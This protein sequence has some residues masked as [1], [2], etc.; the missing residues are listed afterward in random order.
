MARPA[1]AIVTGFAKSRALAE[2]SL[3]PLRQLRQASVLRDI[4]CLTWDSPEIDPYAGWVGSLPGI[5]LTRI[6]QPQ[7]NGTAN[8]RGIVYQI[9]ALRAALTPVAGDALIVKS[10][11]DYVF[12]AAFLRTKIESFA[13]WGTIPPRT[14]FGV[15]MPKPA[16][17]KRIW[18]PWA[19]SNQPF[20]YEDAAFI[21][22]GRDLAR[23]AT[24]LAPQDIANLG[25]E[26]C[27]SFVH[28]VRYAK[29]FLDGYPL[30]ARYLKD[31]RYFAS[32]V[33]YRRKLVPRLWSDGFFWHLLVAHAWVLH[34]HFHVDAGQQGD[35]LFYSNTVNPDADW[36]KP[37]GLRLAN[38]Y[39]RIAQWRDGTRAGLAYPSVQRLYGRVVDDAWQNALFT[40]VL[41]D[42]P[43]ATLARILENVAG[44]RDG[45]FKD[46]EGDF[47]RA[48]AALHAVHGPEAALA[49]AG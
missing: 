29:P 17:H 2:L 5:R 14:V 6:A 37:A 19:D 13:H 44:A 9:E 30:F 25:D 1:D 8:Q 41:P 16:L 36:S 20:Y 35:L 31:Y 28:A 4:H 48:L 23:L 45:R 47:Y 46:I 26:N 27:G 11:P 21:G 3:A 33:A 40:Q 7:A 12:D 10:R 18:V 38:P 42:F 43:R 15:A 32:D 24:P 34:S 39:D 49:K 22:T